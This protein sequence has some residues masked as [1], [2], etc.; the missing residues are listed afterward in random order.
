[1]TMWG[2][3]V[4]HVTHPVM[5]FPNISTSFKLYSDARVFLVPWYDT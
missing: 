4:F 1:M 2:L 5:N 3:V